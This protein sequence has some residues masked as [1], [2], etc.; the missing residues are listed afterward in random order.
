MKWALDYSESKAFA[1]ATFG[2]CP[3]VSSERASFTLCDIKKRSSPLWRGIVKFY[4]V[5]YSMYNVDC[6]GSPCDDLVHQTHSCH[7]PRMALITIE[8][9]ALFHNTTLWRHHACPTI[10]VLDRVNHQARRGEMKRN[11]ILIDYVLCVEYFWRQRKERSNRQSQQTILPKIDHF[12]KHT[13]TVL[14]GQHKSHSEYSCRLCFG[15][16]EKPGT[17]PKNNLFT[18]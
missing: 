11:K 1:P 2:R 12:C 15:K 14:S 4:N 5:A 10:P 16:L 6:L 3:V 9:S 7:S 13:R 18:H 17:T 8:H